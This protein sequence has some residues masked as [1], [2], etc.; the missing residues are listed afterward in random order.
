MEVKE[1]IFSPL[2]WIRLAKPLENS[3][4]CP[5]LLNVIFTPKTSTRT[6]IPATVV[7][8]SLFRANL[9]KRMT[10]MMMGPLRG[11]LKI[12]MIATRDIA[13][14][15][16]DELQRLDFRGYGTRELLGPR[17]YSMN[18]AA[19]IV[20]AAIDK[21]SLTYMQVGDEQ[22]RPAM[23]H[24]GLSQSMVDLILEM[25]AALNSGHMAAL[26]PHSIHN[27]TPTKLETFVS[28]ELVPLY[29]AQQTAA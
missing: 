14:A 26:E 3:P 28:E 16:A 10:G 17:D 18:E 24:M 20:G 1:E 21:P 8:R 29:Q 2:A 13:A 25:S 15:A 6:S 27:T 5:N 23:M 19:L 11:D 7:N 9:I 12:P 4:F 22:L